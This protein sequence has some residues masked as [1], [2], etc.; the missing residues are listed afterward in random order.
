MKFVKSLVSSN[1]L[2]NFKQTAKIFGNFKGSLSRP[3]VNY[4]GKLKKK[5]QET[6]RK[7]WKVE[8]GFREYI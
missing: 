8:Y 6:F 3:K 7:P 1:V 5:N 2:K 4:Q